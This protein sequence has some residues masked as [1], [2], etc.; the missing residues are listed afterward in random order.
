VV[1][2]NPALA[3]IAMVKESNRVIAI[4]FGREF[5]ASRSPDAPIVGTNDDMRSNCVRGGGHD[6]QEKKPAAMPPVRRVANLN[7]GLI[8]DSP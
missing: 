5:P 1:L 7:V 8:T 6:S 4:A 2:A 3:T